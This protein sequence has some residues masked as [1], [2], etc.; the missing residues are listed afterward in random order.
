MIQEKDKP[1]Y[2][3]KKNALLKK[4]KDRSDNRT[5]IK[6][7][8]VYKGEK[9]FVTLQ[10]FAIE[11]EKSGSEG[12]LPIPYLRFLI[13]HVNSSRL[14]KIIEPALKAEGNQIVVEF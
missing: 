7:A 10:S 13:N 2:S 14:T 4:I 8:C 1:V 6:T 3:E 12:G 11:S 5:S 9:I